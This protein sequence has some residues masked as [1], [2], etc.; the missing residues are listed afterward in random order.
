MQ[1]SFLPTMPEDIVAQARTWEEIRD[2]RWYECANGHPC[3]VGECGRPMEKSRCPECHVPI[4][5]RNHKP[6]E[7]FRL[8]RNRPDRTQTGHILADI[9]HRRTLGISDRGMSSTVFVLLRLL[10]HLSMLL[11]ASRD[12]QSLGRMI[13]PTVNDVMSFLKQHIQEDLAQLT[14]SLGKSVDDTINILHLVLSSFLQAPQQQQD[15]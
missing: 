2:L 15:H 14:R 7:G 13:K 3:T 4:G 1:H 11:G 9:E 5:G 6:V 8:S 10:T 12:P